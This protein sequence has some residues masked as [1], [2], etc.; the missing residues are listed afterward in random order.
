MLQAAFAQLE[1]GFTRHAKQRDESGACVTLV[2]CRAGNIAVATWET[3]GRCFL[4]VALIRVG[5]GRPCRNTRMS[6]Q[7]RIV[8]VTPGTKAHHGGRWMRR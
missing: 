2:L 6:L 7:R 1:D 4:I 8:P 5:M 3:A